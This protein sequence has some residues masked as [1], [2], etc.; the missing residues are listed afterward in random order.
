LTQVNDD[1]TPATVN[2]R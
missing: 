1:F 2:N